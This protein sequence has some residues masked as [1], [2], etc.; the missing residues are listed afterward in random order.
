MTRLIPA[1]LANCET[2]LFAGVPRAG[3]KSV[4][5]SEE[6]RLFFLKA[7]LTLENYKKNA[8]KGGEYP[9]FF[10]GEKVDKLYYMYYHNLKIID[11]KNFSD[12]GE[13]M[14]GP[15][16]F[17]EIKE[18]GG[19]GFMEVVVMVIGVLVVFMGFAI[20]GSGIALLFCVLD[21]LI[22]DA[23][24]GF[25]GIFFA[26]VLIAG[27]ICIAVGGGLICKRRGKIA[28]SILET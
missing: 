10:I 20:M 17:P 28:K 7:L 1:G 15:S 16:V 14:P 21:T 9:A 27:G 13:R 8:F 6:S 25:F 3:E 5:W 22:Y 26:L 11:I 2:L 4:A 18:R 23:G 24:K 12:L 19:H